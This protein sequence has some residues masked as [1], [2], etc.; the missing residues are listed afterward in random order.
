MMLRCYDAMNESSQCMPAWP[1]VENPV[2]L[3][4]GNLDL[5]LKVASYSISRLHHTVCKCNAK[6]SMSAMR[7]CC[8][9][10]RVTGRQKRACASLASVGS[11]LGG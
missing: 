6:C 8:S 3:V 4:L 7:D 11:T 10:Q 1:V 2:W 9:D 5:I